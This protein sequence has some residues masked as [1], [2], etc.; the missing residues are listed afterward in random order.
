MGNVY[1]GS[2]LIH[3]HIHNQ[4][5]IFSLSCAVTVALAKSIQFKAMRGGRRK[6]SA[7]RTCTNPSTLVNIQT[8]KHKKLAKKNLV[9]EARHKTQRSYFSA[10]TN[11]YV[12]IFKCAGRA[13]EKKKE[14]SIQNSIVLCN[15]LDF[16]K[17][18]YNITR[19]KQLYIILYI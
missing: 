7:L 14:V 3:T 12:D 10:T 4:H 19:W 5:P 6:W 11:P 9:N 2:W 13:I 8:H 16:I 15:S 18:N 17:T 1:S